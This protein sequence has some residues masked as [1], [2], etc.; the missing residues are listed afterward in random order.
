MIIINQHNYEEF[1]LLYVDGELSATDKQA[2][3]QF[4]QANP[5]LAIE[6]EMLQQ[7][8]L[9]ADELVFEDKDL[10]FRT[11]ETEI[12]LY[13]YEEHFLLYTDN[14]LSNEEKEK[15]ESFVLKHPTLQENFTLLQQTK[16][17][18]ET[19]LF[20][21]KAS[22]YRKVETKKPAFFM[23]WQRI[24]VAA[25]LIGIVALVW[26]LVPRSIS[27]D[28]NLA[29]V[30]TNNKPA[31]TTD[32]GSEKKTTVAGSTNN[33]VASTPAITASVSGNASINKIGKNTATENKPVV[34]ANNLIAT[35]TT[36]VISQPVETIRANIVSGS[37][38]V[39]EAVTAKVIQTLPVENTSISGVDLGKSPNNPDENK[40]Y[41]T[42]NA[43]Q[44]VYKEL[45]TEDDKK[46]LLLGSLEINKD[47]LRGFFR[48][49][50]SLFRSKNK[51]LDDKTDS[52]PASNARSLK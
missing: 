24:A 11:E 36:Q 12:N 6:L 17:E 19:I 15:V 8:M 4:V 20:T 32:F 21:D 29:Q 30:T 22:L 23:G 44:A 7:T 50:G 5:D 45:D 43:Q 40:S 47:K 18:P 46:S 51:D 41:F 10:L 28:Q 27:S 25:A 31:G 16:L 33:H 1:F 42:D 3:E 35:N 48:K 34:E 49:A 38:N 13:N 2:V 39:N 9:A 52:R 14:E 37:S 26:T